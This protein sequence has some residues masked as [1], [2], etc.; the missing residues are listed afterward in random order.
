VNP[1]PE[2]KGKPG[3]EGKERRDQRTVRSPYKPRKANSM[4]S[5]PIP[6]KPGN[7]ISETEKIQLQSQTHTPWE[8]EA[9]DP[10]STRQVARLPVILVS[11]MFCFA[12]FLFFR[13][14]D[15]GTPAPQ[16]ATYSVTAADDAPEYEQRMISALKD[17]LESGDLARVRGV[18]RH[19]D[20]LG[21]IVESYYGGGNPPKNKI[22]EAR[23]PSNSMFLSP[24]EASFLI[25]V[26]TFEGGEQRNLV[27]EW[28]GGEAKID[29]GH[30][31]CY[32]PVPLTDFL[33]PE[34]Q[35]K[36]EHEFRLMGRLPVKYRTSERFAEVRYGC[37]VF[38]DQA[39]GGSDFVAYVLR[40]TETHDQ[41]M[42]YLAGDVAKP[43]IV[44]LRRYSNRDQ[45]GAGVEITGMVTEGWVRAASAA[46]KPPAGD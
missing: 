23:V 29:W 38:Q 15:M 12:A 10:A 14:R 20:A 45:G 7:F 6:F 27:L 31:V 11:V 24:L 5:R 46:A 39:R 42:A 28:V 4:A 19:A 13:S 17:F 18:I 35:P 3:E 33:D 9:P 30:W 1:E 21:D 25:V 22:I 36:D 2:E 26:V 34:R 44:K 8:S 40:G 37:V 32:N 41:L 16:P 43:L